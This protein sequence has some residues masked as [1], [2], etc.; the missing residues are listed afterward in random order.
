MNGELKNLNAE[1][2][3]YNIKLMELEA[4]EKDI[5][6]NFDGKSDGKGIDNIQQRKE[7]K[8]ANNALKTEIHT[9]KILKEREKYDL[10][11]EVTEAQTSIEDMRDN[12]KMYN[13]IM[14][15]RK[16]TLLMK[17]LHKN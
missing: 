2:E 10:S 3:S 1:I 8:E 13:N 7:L 16:K 12:L 11:L 15:D 9:K 14:L 4:K 5:I 6:R 17:Y